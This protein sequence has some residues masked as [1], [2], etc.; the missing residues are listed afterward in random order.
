MRRLFV[1]PDEFQDFSPGEKGPDCCY[2]VLSLLSYSLPRLARLH[3]PRL[4]HQAG[5]SC[6]SKNTGLFTQ[7]PIPPSANRS[8][9]PSKPRSHALTT[10]FVSTVSW[11]PVGRASRSMS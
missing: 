5:S 8:R 3:K 9:H 10:T 2:A 11:P 6:P 7:G 4:I 1:C